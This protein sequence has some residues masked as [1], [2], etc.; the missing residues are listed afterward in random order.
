MTQEERINAL[1]SKVNELMKII[2]IG[3]LTLVDRFDSNRKV[4]FEYLNDNFTVKKVT[5]STEETEI[6]L[7]NITK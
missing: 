2:S 6:Q 3:K 7:I 1:E 4:V 5:T